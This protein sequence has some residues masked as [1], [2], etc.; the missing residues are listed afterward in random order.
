MGDVLTE[1]VGGM[2]AMARPLRP[3]ALDPFIQRLGAGAVVVAEPGGDGALPSLR[4]LVGLTDGPISP[5]VRYMHT[6]ASDNMSRRAGRLGD[7]ATRRW[8]P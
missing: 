1:S 6:F 4:D 3:L 7:A 5:S 8:R 2:R